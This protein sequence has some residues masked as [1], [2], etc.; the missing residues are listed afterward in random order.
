M[1]KNQA[2]VEAEVMEEA[3]VSPLDPEREQE[4]AQAQM[5]A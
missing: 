3:L 2:L 1:L 4:L 5:L